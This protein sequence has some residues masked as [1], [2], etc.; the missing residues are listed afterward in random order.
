MYARLASSAVMVAPAYLVILELCLVMTRAAVIHVLVGVTADTALME[1]TVRSV[2]RAFSRMRTAQ[3]VKRVLMLEI[4]ITQLLAGRV[5][6]VL[7]AI[8]LLANSPKQ[9]GVAVMTVQSVS[10]ATAVNASALM[11]TMMHR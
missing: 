6:S 5:R 8:T 7:L 1:E 2:V 9:I 10:S 11:A 3:T 4:N